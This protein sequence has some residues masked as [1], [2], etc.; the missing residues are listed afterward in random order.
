MPR[1][2]FLIAFALLG[3]AN[4]F[5]QADKKGPPPLTIE[6]VAEDLYVII[7]DGGNVGLLV[8]NEGCILIDDKFERDFDTILGLVKSVTNQPVKYIFNT[9]YHSDH[10][11]GNTRFI[12]VAEVISHKN[13]RANIEGNKQS[14]AE[15]NMK[16]ARITFT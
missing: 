4:A 10:S 2:F 8:T 9:H 11:G 12:G 13:S 1:K 5:A 14:N 3:I 16:A 7:G 6:K 15:P